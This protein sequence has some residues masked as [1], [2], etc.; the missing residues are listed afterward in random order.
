MPTFTYDVPLNA[1]GTTVIAFPSLVSEQEFQDILRHPLPSSQQTFSPKL[2]SWVPILS[3][4]KCADINLYGSELSGA[5][6]G[7]PED[8]L[9]IFDKG[10][11]KAQESSR[12]SFAM[13]GTAKSMETDDL[14][15]P[16]SHIIRPTR[17]LQHKPPSVNP[18]YAEYGCRKVSRQPVWTEWFTHRS[19]KHWDTPP[20]DRPGH[21]GNN[22]LSPEVVGLPPKLSQCITVWIWKEGLQEW[23]IIEYGDVQIINGLE[24]RWILHQSMKKKG[25]KRAPRKRG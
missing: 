13:V 19:T 14:D 10:K 25:Y 15:G 7:H 16:S 22:T 9:P 20:P 12:E 21:I 3:E 5:F 11:G 6:M 18:A 1:V 17:M 2:E 4:V 24:P 23:Q 8:T